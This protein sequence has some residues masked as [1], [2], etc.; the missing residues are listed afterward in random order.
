MLAGRPPMPACI[1]GRLALPAPQPTPQ[2]TPTRSLLAPRS[3]DLTNLPCHPVPLPPAAAEVLD[4]MQSMLGFTPEDRA[5]IAESRKRQGWR[6][7]SLAS[8]VQA[9]GGG[10]A[11]TKAS[12]ADSWVDF[13][14]QQLEADAAAGAGG[15]A[16]AAP[17][18]ASAAA[19]STPTVGGGSSSAG[20]PTVQQQGPPPP[21]F[22]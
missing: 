16:G 18:E 13:L 10:Q 17:Q 8:D 5:K 2:P 4:L 19:A 1:P 14:Q 3:M 22:L 12:L 21:A 20:T 7:I 9:P 6:E 11:G 15:A